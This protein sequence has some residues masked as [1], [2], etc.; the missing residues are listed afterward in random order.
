[1]ELNLN[2]KSGKFVQK[3]P[4]GLVLGGGGAKATIYLGLFEVLEK[5]GIRVDYIAGTSMG[6]I[7]G[8]AYAL[9]MTA[10]EMQDYF[11]KNK[12]VN[13]TGMKNFNFFNESL[14]KRDEFNKLLYGLCGD[15]KFEDTKIPF[16]CTAVDLEQKKEVIFEKGKMF[17]ALQA[18]SAYPP[19][20]P[21]VFHEGK[22]LI[23][24]GIIDNVPALVARGMERDELEG[25]KIMAFKLNNNINRQYISGH[26]FMKHYGL[27][28][29]VRNWNIFKK[30]IA[31]MKFVADIVL[32]AISIASEHNVRRNLMLA[33]PEI[34]VEPVVEVGLADFSQTEKLIEMG[35]K[36]G[37]T[38][39]PQIKKVL[40]GEDAGSG[41]RPAI[42]ED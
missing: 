26:I 6:A 28:K 7:V 34:L 19:L 2:Q 1:M 11:T 36:I 35:R 33:N 14:F 12:D 5:N 32:E 3:K 31:D 10:Q 9:G 8:G 39:M 4:F 13:L 17:E 16:K 22:Y 23:D 42:V 18:T 27:G 41:F 38:Y 30:K 15:K 29:K 20:L 25:G 21:P 40:S 24:G 37:K